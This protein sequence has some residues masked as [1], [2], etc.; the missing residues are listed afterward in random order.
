MPVP[1]GMK[2]GARGPSAHRP[3]IGA[4]AADTGDQPV[5]R[6]NVDGMARCLAAD[7]EFLSK[8]ILGGEAVACLQLSLGKL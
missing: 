5:R 7:A 8:L 3:D 6:Q 1:S 2:P 4:A